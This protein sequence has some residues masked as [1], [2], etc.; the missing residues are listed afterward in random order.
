M[1]PWSS[2]GGIQAVCFEQLRVADVFRVVKGKKGEEEEE[3]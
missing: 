2:C 1:V 3:E